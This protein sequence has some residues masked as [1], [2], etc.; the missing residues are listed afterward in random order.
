MTSSCA[1]VQGQCLAE[2]GY[3]AIGLV[4]FLLT[5][6][7]RHIAN[8]RIRREVKRILAR[9]GYTKTTICTRKSL[10]EQK[11]WEDEIL[12]EVYAVRD[13]YAA[14]HGYD[15]ERIYA[16]LKRREASSGLRRAEARP[17]RTADEIAEMA[18]RGEDVSA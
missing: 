10:G 3:G 2:D 9:H 6:N 18:S 1:A 16:D 11:P 7:L 17:L 5:W 13:A 15:L 14:E 12:R 8:D 4:Q